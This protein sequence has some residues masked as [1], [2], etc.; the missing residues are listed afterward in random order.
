MIQANREATVRAVPVPLAPVLLRAHEPR[1]HLVH[2]LP[3]LGG[4]VLHDGVV[5]YHGHA[6]LV[7]KRLAHVPRA[8]EKGVRD[9]RE[10]ALQRVLVLADVPHEGAVVA[11]DLRGRLHVPT[12]SRSK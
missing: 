1:G 11:R 10:R 5:V 9:A 6:A 4:G 3:L 8:G 2:V 7:G 12:L